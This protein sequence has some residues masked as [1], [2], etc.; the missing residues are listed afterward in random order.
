[1]IALVLGSILTAG[2]SWQAMHPSSPRRVGPHLEAATPKGTPPTGSLSEGP[3]E[4]QAWEISRLADPKTGQI[5]PDIH[6]REQAFAATLPRWEGGSIAY[7]E[8]Q[9]GRA[10]KLEGWQYRGPWNIGG[11]TRALAIDVSSDLLNP[12][13]LAGG[14]SGGLW[15]S[16]DDGVSWS[17]TTGSSQL[18]SVT[19]VVQDT[20]AGHENTWYYGTGEIRGNSASGGGAASFRGDGVFRSS[21]GGYNWSLLL[22]T[23][24]TSPSSFSNDWQYVY[25]LVVDTGEDFDDEIYAAIF[26]SIQ[27]STDGGAS[28]TSVLGDANS[29]SRYTDVVIT[30]EGVLYASL[31]SDGGTSGIFRSPDGLIWTDI[32]PA[33][34]SSHNRIVL[35]I[36]PTEETKVYALVADRNGTTSEGFYRYNYFSGDGSGPDGDWSDRSV[37]MNSLPGLNGDE[38]METYSSYCQMVCVSPANSDVVYIGGLNLIRSGDGFATNTVDVRI[39]G[40]G[41]LDHHADQHTL[42]F[43][44]GAPLTAYSGSDGGVHRSTNLFDA[45]VTWTSLNNGYNTSQFYAVAIDENL[46]DSEVL[47]GGMQDNGSWFVGTSQ[48]ML[49][50]T[51]LL[52]GDGGFCAVSDASGVTGSYVVSAQNGVVYRMTADNG[53]GAWVTWTRVDPT[54][55]GGY[56]FINP[57][58]IDPNSV[59]QL[60]VATSAGIWRNSDL[61]AIPLWSDLT[62][63]Q[64]WVH[65]TS[66]PANRPV[67]S[68]AMTIGPTPDLWYGTSSG[69]VYRLDDA[70]N[71]PLNSVPV[72]IDMGVDWPAGAYVSDIDISSWDNGEMLVAVSNYNVSSIFYSDDFGVSWSEVEGNLAGVDGPSVRAISLFHFDGNDYYFA[73]T[74]TG[75]YSSAAMNGAATVW[76]LEAPDLMGNVVVDQLASRGWDGV[77]VAGTHGKGVYS[78]KIQVGAAVDDGPSRTRVALRQNVPNPFNPL[79]LISFDLPRSGQVNLSVYDVAGRHVRTLV[80]GGLAAGEHSFSWSGVD[81]R[82][83]QVSAGIYLYHLRGLGLDEVRRMTLVR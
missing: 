39:G 32:T 14:V 57:L 74:S 6:R 46:V 55:A 79:T 3:T 56:L 67:A 42:V 1:M 18:H 62:T 66:L 27:R 15:R 7:E 29:K 59:D 72:L 58:L 53:T 77:L 73:A 41:Y 21:D 82:G 50:W 81:E 69:S 31:S 5:P 48:T 63:S 75:L 64:N 17:L 10:K 16:D 28:W 60:Y 34:L 54:G 51:E 76:T 80:D 83:R 25:R 52:S 13:L 65:I 2:A 19:S 45:T 37:Q 78:L 49:P 33:S 11:R 61:A 24:G 43:L 9:F 44:P 26:G 23:S 68:M 22:A 30:S 35:A 38:P 71:A 8:N 40:S 70:K 47:I 12:T 36:A 4:R 20:R